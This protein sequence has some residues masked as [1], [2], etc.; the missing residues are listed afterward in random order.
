MIEFA[1]S[2]M[3][4]QHQM[5]KSVA[6]RQYQRSEEAARANRAFQ[7]RMSNTAYQRA[8]A[9]MR[10]A[11]LNPI[12]AAKLGGASTPSGA[13]ATA[14]QEKAIDFAAV[15][16]AVNSAKKAKQEARL[17]KQE[18][19]Y[20][21]SKK[22]P[23]SVGTQRPLNTFISEYLAN[24]KQEDKQNLYDALNAMFKRFSSNA[25]TISEGSIF[26]LFKLLFMGQDP[27]PNENQPTSK[28]LREKLPLI[29]GDV[30]TKNRLRRMGYPDPSKER[31]KDRYTRAKRYFQ[32]IPLKLR[33]GAKK[34][35]K[36]W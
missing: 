9:D 21:G 23:K 29:G 32:S 8:M 11:G 15:S 2:Y 3:Y 24:M 14:P 22:Y 20:Y 36:E 34:G 30:F 33:R 7:E 10:Q 1:P 16:Q 18:A 28:V 12:L 26:D 19:D 31:K 4:M 6:S 25:K 5:N 27:S 13:T 17:A 35:F